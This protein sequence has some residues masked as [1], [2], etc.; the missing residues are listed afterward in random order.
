MD[1]KKEGHRVAM[2]YLVQREDVNLFK[3]AFDIDPEYSNALKDAYQNGLEI[4]VYQC[5]LT[6]KEITVD[7]KLKFEFD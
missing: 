2:F 3:P 6:T 1:M 7:R 5:K 4:L